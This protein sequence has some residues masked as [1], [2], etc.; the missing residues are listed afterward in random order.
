[1]LEVVGF[2]QLRKNLTTIERGIGRIINRGATESGEPD[3]PGIFNSAGLAWRNRK[4]DALRNA[5][6]GIE[7][8]F[9]IRPDERAQASEYFIDF[10]TGFVRSEGG[11][12]RFNQFLE[13]KNLRQTSEQCLR[14]LVFESSVA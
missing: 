7:T 6:R 9:I 1:M 4:N 8:G 5:K 11:F 2:Y 13:C 14:P 3:E 10:R 12:D